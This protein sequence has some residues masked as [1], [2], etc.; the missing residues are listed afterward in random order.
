[1]YDHYGAREVFTD[2]IFDTWG[3]VEVDDHVAFGSRTGPVEGSDGPASSL[4][5]GGE[6]SSDSPLIGRKLT[7][8]EALRHPLLPRF[9]EI[10]DLI[11]NE[12]PLST[13]IGQA[14][15]FDAVGDF[16]SPLNDHSTKS[17][18]RPQLGKAAPS[19]QVR[20]TSGLQTARDAYGVVRPRPVNRLV[21]GWRT[22]L[23]R[24]STVG[25]EQCL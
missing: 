25:T 21:S 9:W 20:A 10:N 13:S 23:I 24:Y 8:D 17:L 15:R 4:V 11:L 2:G 5:T 16:N 19:R 12:I 1:M 14:I 6:M 22:A 3:E 18:A 7:R